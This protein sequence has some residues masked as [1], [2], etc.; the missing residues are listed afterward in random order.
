MNYWLNRLHVH[1]KLVIRIIDTDRNKVGIIV[2]CSLC[3]SVRISQECRLLG[4]WS[5]EFT[6]SY[7][8]F[9]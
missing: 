6:I 8:Y 3:I 1:F 9:D 4:K 5:E 7:D 2:N